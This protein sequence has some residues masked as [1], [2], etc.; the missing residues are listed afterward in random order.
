M[1]GFT[2]ISSFYELSNLCANGKNTEI[3]ED[4]AQEKAGI[5]KHRVPLISGVTQPAVIQILEETCKKEEAPLYLAGRDFTREKIATGTFHFHGRQWDLGD[6]RLGVKG[7]FQ[8]ENAVVALG[9]MEVLEEKG[10]RVCEK[11]IYQGLATVRWPGR[12]E[13]VQDSP[14]IILDGAHN[15]AAARSLKQ[16]LQEEFDYQ[17]LYMVM[18]IMQDK[19]VAAIVAEL[20][21]LA[22]ELIAVNPRNPRAMR[23]QQLADIAQDYCGEVTVIEDVGEAA[24]YAQEVAQEDDLILVT[25]SLFTVGEARDHI[26]SRRQRS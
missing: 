13:V 17:H 11:S 10:Y 25:G 8:I 9:A 15:P 16:A 20:A 22:E 4:I 12:L 23:A 7:S 14:Q 24:A 1:L 26:V 18:G 2:V 5:V 21:P 3:F 19:E 6:I